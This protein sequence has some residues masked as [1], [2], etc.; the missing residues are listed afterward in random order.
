[1]PLKYPQLKRLKAPKST[2]RVRAHQWKLQTFLAETRHHKLTMKDLKERTIRGGA[3]RVCALG[4]TFALR[5]VSLMFLARLLDPREFGLVGMVTAFTGVLSLFRDFGLSA[6]AIQHTTITEEQSST[7]FWINLLVGAVLTL[8]AVVL[9]PVI[10]RFYHEPQLAWITATVA[11]GF[12]FNAAGVQHSALLQ[13]QMRFTELAVIDVISLLVGA[14]VGIAAAIAGYGYWA[15]V[16][17]TLSMP[18]T[19]TLGVWWATKW[20]PG[21]PRTWSDIRLL[22]QFGSTLT[23]NG[24]VLYVAFNLD[25]VL[26]GRFWGP[27]AIG[28]YGRA[29]Q[30]SRIPTDNLNSAIGDVAFSALS[31]I[32]DDPP[33]LRRYFLQ[34][35]SLVVAMTLPV[36]IGCAVFSDDVIGVLLGPKWKAAGVI[37]RLLSPTILMF[38]IL[39][40]LG[41]LLNALGLVGRGLKISMVLAPLMMVG[42]LLGL[43]HGPKG[44]A[45]AYS[46]L[47]LLWG[48]PGIAWAV[49]G[50]V[51]SFRDV[52]SAVV[53]PLLSAAAAAAVALGARTVYGHTLSVL[54]RLILEGSVLVASYFTLLLFVAGQKTVLYDLIRT[55][56]GTSKP[57]LESLSPV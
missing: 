55:Y 9:G 25:K 32:Q 54:L 29:Y 4:G 57:K 20:V 35:Y 16:A 14:L 38:A 50:T 10:S 41:W 49:H 48:L 36:A 40:P 17:M 42:Y 51:I 27:E 30:L 43:S 13:R 33:R 7:L 46:A 5:I 52:G 34:G 6:A 1:V 37:F 44:V 15:L 12:V 53:R 31:R 45:L 18:I 56:R 19:N 47:M 21:M 3:V 26:L 24:L 39:N 22:V 11:T 28:I 23:L 2:A 8:V